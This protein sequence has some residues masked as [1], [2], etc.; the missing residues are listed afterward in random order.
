MRVEADARPWSQYFSSYPPELEEAIQKIYLT[1]K[2]LLEKAY[3]A[4]QGP[5]QLKLLIPH[6]MAPLKQPLNYVLK[7]DLG[8]LPIDVSRFI[9]FSIQGQDVIFLNELER[10]AITICAPGAKAFWSPTEKTIKISME[11]FREFPQEDHVNLQMAYL[12][13]ELGN[14]ANQ[15]FF[16][17]LRYSLD[18]QS[19]ILD[20]IEAEEHQVYDQTGAY[21]KEIDFPDRLNFFRFKMPW[22]V[23]RLYAELSGHLEQTNQFY[24]NLFKKKEPLPPSHWPH[25]LSPKDK[26][27]LKGL[28]ESKAKALSENCPRKPALTKQGTGLDLNWRWVNRLW[29]ESTR[30]P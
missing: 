17:R 26:K 30:A 18:S 29:N 28:I 21:L 2:D 4:V 25:P 3:Q 22:P 23:Y 27:V 8:K 14:A 6:D 7:E 1:S 16:S 5:I 10:H 12:A 9:T 15:Q 13:F 11:A 24:N 19:E 20:A